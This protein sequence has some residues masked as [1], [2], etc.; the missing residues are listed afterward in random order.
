MNLLK[1]LLKTV[2]M[3]ISALALSLAFVSSNAF[4]QSGAIWTTDQF[5]QNQNV[6]SFFLGQAVWL[7]GSNMSPS[8]SLAYEITDGTGASAPVIQSGFV[9]TDALGDITPHPVKVWDI[10]INYVPINGG[11]FKVKV[12]DGGTKSDNFSVAALATSPD[13]G[14]APDPTYPSLE[15]NNGAS[16][17]D[18]TMEWLGTAVDGEADSAQVDLDNFDDGVVINGIFEPAISTSIDV[19]V[20]TSGLASS[21]YDP[22]FDSALLYLNAWADWNGDGDWNDPDEKIIGT[23]SVV[24]QVQLDPNTFGG[25]S[26]ALNYNI[27][28]PSLIAKSFYLRFRLDFGE[29]AG[30]VSTSGVS[31]MTGRAMF[32]EVEDY[33]YNNNLSP[34]IDSYLP[35]NLTPTMNEADSLDFSVTASDAN[36]EDT[37]TYSWLLDIVEVSTTNAYT[38]TPGYLDAGVH[39]VDVIVSDG[40]GGTD[41]RHWDITVNNLNRQP[42]IDSYL[43][44]N[45]TPSVDEGGTLPLSI[46][47]SDPDTDDTLTY[48]WLLDSIEVST[49]S[50]FDYNPDFFDAGLHTIDATVN[51]G[52]GGLDTQHWD[53]T[54]TNVNLSP[55]ADAGGPYAGVEGSSIPV[56]GSG[57]TDTDGSIV[58]FEW[59]LDNDGQ[60]DDSTGANTTAA[61]SDNGVFTVNL[62]VTDNDG[63]VGTA[64]TTINVSN[65]DPVVDAGAGG[66]YIA[67]EDQS[68]TLDGSAADPGTA[69][70]HTF[71]WDLDN[72]GQFDDA[73]GASTNVTFA[74]PG[75]YT[76][77]L[78]VTDDD[79]GIGTDTAPVTVNNVNDPPAT[80]IDAL[81]ANITT[82]SYTITGTASD[83]DGAGQPTT[84]KVQ[85]QRQ[86]NSQY[87]NGTAWQAGAVE[88]DAANTG[89][90]FSS[91]QY[92]WNSFGSMNGV[93]V[94][95]Q[96]RAFDGAL[97]DSTPATDSSLVDNIGNNLPD[98][99]LDALPASI[100]TTSYTITGTA[101]DPDG[102]GEPTAVKVQIQRQDNSQYWNGTV[103]QAGAV[104]VDAANTDVDFSTWQYAWNNFGSI[105]GITVT[106]QARAFDGIAYDS[107]PA[108]DSTLVNNVNDPPVTTVDPLP[109]AITTTSYTITGTASDP[110]G[111]GEPIAVKIQL[112]RQDNAQF[113][114]GA[115][116]QPVAVEVDATNTGV[117]F[118]TWEYNWVNFGSINGAGVAIQARAFDGIAYDSSPTVESSQVDNV[119]NPP[120]I[121][122]YSPVNL[123]PNVDEGSSLGFSVTASDP[124]PGDTL[125]YSWLLD[126][127]EVSTTT[128]YTY[129]PG[130]SDAGIHTV[131]VTV[132]DGN[133]G[134]ETQHWDVTVTDVNLPP[135]ID[136]Y[137]PVNLNPSVEEGNSLPF[138]VTA[139]DPDPGDSLTYS[140]LLDSVEVSTE[141]SYTYNPGTGDAGAHTLDVNIDDGKGGTESQQWNIN[142]TESAPTLIELVS[143]TAIKQNGTVLVNWTTVSEI[144]NAGFNLWKSSKRNGNFMKINSVLIPAAGSPVLGA[145]YTFT[146]TEAVRGPVYYYLEDIDFNGTATWHGE[147]ACTL[148]TDP[149]CQP[150]RPR[151]LKGKK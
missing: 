15:V 54:V 103:W 115:A 112:Q 130:F 7:A 93:T 17:L 11:Q 119:P 137:S 71:E 104:E 138:S 105:N 141:S 55:I 37:L 35:V 92:A 69:D 120:T 83:P 1:K 136:F 32:G 36:P 77:G 85:I 144:D 63:G 127:V 60:Y 58:S 109:A 101:T 128:D 110:D 24:G 27:T 52:K 148:G 129:S 51:D 96:A 95:I 28:P 56:D 106:I 98:T 43:P 124:D 76:V 135:A 23:G 84:V 19:L 68:I 31:E 70:T 72:D 8:T 117:D 142:V 50:S 53:V 5:R 62:R 26:T 114:N 38:Y 16:H 44:L 118:S 150:V 75:I 91:W 81:P 88:V 97:F 73:T 46:T 67:D 21:R 133:G 33:A 79:G 2:L 9:D 41:S 100:T 143:F 61:F 49:S 132:S 14:D 90:D 121:D 131:D 113:W 149:D 57:S 29:D 125:T 64:S 102:A 40:N 82:T 116:W 134:S 126:G 13:Y 74:D 34:V 86:D 48:S 59:D 147:G 65:A 12:Y 140:W 145:N 18:I 151:P 6:N 78:R 45:L 139:S 122:L 47:S 108:S 89:V 10:P 4:A 66:P 42:T 20:N 123:T 22:A 39:T 80:T 111:P 146:D 30:F 3:F 99:S 94:T 107:A 25:N 87:W